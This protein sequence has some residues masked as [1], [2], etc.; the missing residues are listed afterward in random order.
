MFVCVT[1]GTGFLGAHTVAALV[2]A[3]HRVRVL[4]RDPAA[5]GP[6]LAP[7]GVP[8]GVEAVPGDI[9]DEPS[10]AAAVRGTDGV[11]HA[12]SVYSFDSRRRAEIRATNVRGTEVVLAAALRAG[13][14]RVVSVSTFGALL[15]SAEPVLH[16]GS[17]VGTPAEVYMAGKAV[18]EAL[19]RRHQAAGA[20]LVITYPAALFGPDDPKLGDQNG[21]LRDLLRG[22]MPFWPLGHLPVGDV[23]DTAA[24]HAR[25]FDEPS[26]PQ[27]VF[28]PG[29]HLT[30]PEFV[31][32]VRAVTGRKLPALFLPAAAMAPLSRVADVVQRGW[33]WHIPAEFGAL[34]ACANARPVARETALERIPPR[35]VEDTLADTVGWLHRT[36][37]LSARQAGAAAAAVTPPTAAAA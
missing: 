9:T 26:P 19:A 18:S 24:L 34:Y 10:V 8:R 21:R 30:T 28:G 16:A 7:L 2:R 1:G 12:A 15:P 20:P 3:G 31:D 35:P 27:R 36:G 5:V 23:R 29:H 4:A 6:A 13:V 33:P 17:P 11:L 14:R 37:R 22:L 25:L 32:V